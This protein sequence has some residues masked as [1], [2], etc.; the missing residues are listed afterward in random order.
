M[1]I[2]ERLLSVLRLLWA[3][4]TS[5]L[6]VLL[7]LPVVAAGGTVRRIGHTLEVALRRRTLANDS[8]WRRSRFGA[9]TLG[10]VIIGRTHAELARL[11]AH[12]R[13]HVRQCER[14][15]PLFLPAYAASS[16]AA[17][18]RGD[19]PYR[20]NR[21]EIEAYASDVPSTRYHAAN[22]RVTAAGEGIQSPSVSGTR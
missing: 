9:I 8:V 20:G 18:W 7:A 17:W 13:V 11:R 22:A 15:G 19:C 16:V 1:S 5:L 12:E 10:H 4:P 14:L 21:F 3:S 6:G 2:R